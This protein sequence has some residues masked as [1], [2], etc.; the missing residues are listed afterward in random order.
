MSCIF[1]LLGT[2]IDDVG[3]QSRFFASWEN[4][5]LTIECNDSDIIGRLI[6]PLCD[7]EQY[8]FIETSKWFTAILKIAASPQYHIT[9]VEFINDIG[10]KSTCDMGFKILEELSNKGMDD[11]YLNTCREITKKCGFLLTS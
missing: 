9:Q 7:D 6:L 11:T 5:A 1:E 3:E 2:I 8:R 4:E 10:G